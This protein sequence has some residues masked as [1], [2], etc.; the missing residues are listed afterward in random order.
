MKQAVYS[1]LNQI[2]EKSMLKLG[3]LDNIQEKNILLIINVHPLKLPFH[4]IPL[5]IKLINT[6]YLLFCRF[7]PF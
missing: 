7:D 1:A 4:A 5:A 3:V 6:F 2:E